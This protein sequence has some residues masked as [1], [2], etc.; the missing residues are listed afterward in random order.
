MAQPIYFCKLVKLW[1]LTM[2][3]SEE[4]SPDVAV[5]QTFKVLVLGDSG[6]G[7]TSLIQYY[8]QRAPSLNMISTVGK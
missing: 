8:K 3:S 1:Y 6:V 4:S 5:A 7:K 2:S